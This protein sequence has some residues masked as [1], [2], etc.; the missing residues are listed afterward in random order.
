MRPCCI[1]R[2]NACHSEASATVA[3]AT[4]TDALDSTLSR[5]LERSC[6]SLPVPIFGSLIPPIP[7]SRIF[8]FVGF[9]KANLGSGPLRPTIRQAIGRL[10][11]MSVPCVP[12]LCRA[13]LRPFVAL[14]F[15]LTICGQA[16][17][18]PA[19]TPAAEP[20]RSSPLNLPLL[21]VPVRRNP[22]LADPKSI[23]AFLRPWLFTSRLL[24]WGLG[25]AAQRTTRSLPQPRSYRLTPDPF[26]WT[27]NST[28]PDEDDLAYLPDVPRA[29]YRNTAQRI[30]DLGPRLH[31]S[32]HRVDAKHDVTR[33]GNRDV[34]E[35]INFF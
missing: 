30:A 19:F 12:S 10:P 4:T 26:N 35:G 24:D 15:L 25:P 17:T 33:I 3:S 2:T 9:C 14:C 1:M 29:G 11:R 22:L 16:Q 32:A 28:S 34:G 21:A 31:A 13:T 23:A 27:L 20:A 5:I 8:F 18:I 6:A 7:S